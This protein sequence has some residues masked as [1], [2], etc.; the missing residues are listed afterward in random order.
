[1]HGLT[2]AGH[3]LMAWAVGITATTVFLDVGPGFIRDHPPLERRIVGG[4]IGP[5]ALLSLLLLEVDDPSRTRLLE[6]VPFAVMALAYS[7][8]W[9]RGWRAIHRRALGWQTGVI[10]G[11]ALLVLML[12]AGPLDWHGGVVMTAYAASAALLGGLTCLLVKA[13]CGARSDDVDVTLTPYGLP[14]RVVA[15]GIAISV[16]GAFDLFVWTLGGHTEW[17]PVMGSWL[18]LSLAVPGALVALGHKLYPRLQRV[19]WAVA[20][21]SAVGGQAVLHTIT[22]YY[23]GLIPPPLI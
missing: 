11:V 17:L 4:L 2:V 15:I 3:Q 8:A 5:V 18:G 21:T 23:P 19:I 10:G 9:W 6:A 13:L 12:T 20:L 1:M 14:A 16:L 22:L 7:L